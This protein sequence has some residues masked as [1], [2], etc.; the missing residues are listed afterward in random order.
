MDAAAIDVGLVGATL[1]ERYEVLELLGRG[2][3]GEVYRALDRELDEVVALKVVHGQVA[4]VP[5]VVERFRA[6]VK[7]A[8]RVTHKNVARTFELG[9]S[10][11]LL[12]FTMELVTGTSLA[13][14]LAAGP[15]PATEAIAVAVELCEALAAAHAA[16]VIHRD[17]KPD[18][19]M[20]ADD[21]R[22]VLTDFGVAS[23]S[24]D[25]AEGAS[26]TP[27]YMAPEQARGE[28][29]TPRVDVYALGLVLYEMLVGAPAFDG[30]LET[31]LTA[32]QEPTPPPGLDQLEPAL[33]AV[34]T[35]AIAF[36]PGARWPDVLALRHALAPDTA[37]GR[38]ARA[39]APGQ[40]FHGLPTVQVLPL[41]AAP[42]QAWLALGLQDEL[43]HRLARRQHLRLVRGRERPLADGAWV[44]VS[45]DPRG[46]TVAVRQPGRGD[47]LALHVE[48]EVEALVA[49]AE[50]AS[51]VIAAAVGAGA[52][53]GTDDPPLP[54]AARAHVW[55]ATERSR[56]DEIDRIAAR[57]D[58]EAA[59][60]LAPDDPRIMAGLAMAE[61]R[62]AFFSE[63]PEPEQLAR[64]VRRAGRA[65][66]VAPQL[67]E[68]HIAHGRVLLHH[69]DATAAA[70]HFRTA[71]ARA[72]YLTD[73]HE[74]LG[75]MLLE[76]G[77]LVE[78]MARMT[79]ALEMDP[80]LEQPRWDLARAY[81]L[82]ERWPEY[83]LL[84]HELSQRRGGM[85]SY[86]ALALRTAGWRGD[87]ATVARVQELKARI[88][89]L[90]V[91]E[92]ALIDAVCEALLNDRWHAVRDQIVAVATIGRAL[93]SARR[94]AFVAQII[95]EVAGIA[96][97]AETSM[98][99][100][101]LAVDQGLFD[102]HWLERCP[103][104]AAVRRDPRYA[105]LHAKV[106]ARAHAILDALYG[107]HAHRA[108]ADTM[109]VTPTPL[110]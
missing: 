109:L 11:G 6:E 25:A 87:R 74:W 105:A 66:A 69:G 22:V 44:Q 7:L 51:R 8:R 14:R 24:S 76:G 104:L 17:L 93:G 99:M 61:V 72:P 47:H 58:W 10:D 70:V 81:A 59:A 100:L 23:L 94:R 42:E 102:R 34:V 33:A 31:V 12:Y 79:D 86:L 90:P 20:L 53:R 54:T 75:R 68:A 37:G 106:S 89:D 18:N 80:D 108:T 27:R 4:Q 30:G 43:L 40:P 16:G 29:P 110:R 9:A 13:D 49:G 2:G 73:P 65:V 71:I 67:A 32:K 83:D 97:D 91:F 28:P 107:D 92:G 85:A 98:R 77:F 57:H 88:P 38:P 60:A 39:R 3:M 26:G 95:A 48:L 21:G 35:R 62:A 50:L 15:L 84:V 82:E 19:V 41:A 55:R 56:H 96:G 46:A 103:P 64:A 36:D 5:G 101:T 78:G 1:A 63:P 45:A 52:E